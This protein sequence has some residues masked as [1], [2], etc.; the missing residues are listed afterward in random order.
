MDWW[1]ACHEE[2]N[3]ATKDPLREGDVALNLSRFIRSPVGKVWSWEWCQLRCRPR[4][5]GIV[6]NFEVRANGPRAASK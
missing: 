5:L 4:R 1:L 6:Q 2:S 3:H